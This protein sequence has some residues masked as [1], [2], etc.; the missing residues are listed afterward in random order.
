MPDFEIPEIAAG[1]AGGE[2]YLKANASTEMGQLKKYLARFGVQAPD[3][4]GVQQGS[5]DRATQN[6]LQSMWA[7]MGEI[8]L[9]AQL[10][11]QY[12]DAMQQQFDVQQRSR[13]RGMWG[14]GLGAL[15][16]IGGGLLGMLKKKPSP[17]QPAWESAQGAMDWLGM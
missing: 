8:Q 7:R 3:Y 15:G 9:R 13:K 4:L 16:Q 10:R 11:Q 14:T 17:V 2:E 6:A 1:A 12:Q 5:M